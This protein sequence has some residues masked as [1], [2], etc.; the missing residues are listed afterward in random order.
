VKDGQLKMPITR[1]RE[2]PH[3]QSA[4]KHLPLLLVVVGCPVV[5]QIVQQIWLIEGAHCRAGQVQ[6]ANGITHGLG[7]CHGSCSAVAAAA[8]ALSTYK[9]Q[10]RGEFATAE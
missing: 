4:D 3:L 9:A 2:L 6:R 10:G 5:Q 1:R 8:V 7:L